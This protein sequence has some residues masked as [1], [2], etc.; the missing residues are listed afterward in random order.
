MALKYKDYYSSLGVSRDAS[1]DAI[2]KAF[3]KLARDHHP[4]VAK[5][6]KIGRPSCR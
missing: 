3:R 1:D 6:K 5:D 4:D 2:K